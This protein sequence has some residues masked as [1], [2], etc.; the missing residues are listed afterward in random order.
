MTQAKTKAF[1]SEVTNKL[2]LFGTNPAF[3][4]WDNDK[5]YHLNLLLLLSSVGAFIFTFFN[6]WI[7]NALLVGCSLAI[8]GYNLLLFYLQYSQ[9][10]YTARTL[11][12]VGYPILF[13]ALIVCGQGTI[14]A[15]YA[16]F[17]MTLLC[18]LFFRSTWRLMAM[19]AYVF[20]FYLISQVLLLQEY[21]AISDWSAIVNN[22]ILFL[23][24]SFG[25]VFITN[26][27]I[28]EII[29][30]NKKNTQLLSDLADSNEELKRLNYMVSHDLRT[31]LRH[32][33]SF[34]KIAQ[35]ASQKGEPS[36]SQ[37]YM[38]L[39]ENSARELYTMTENLLSLAHLDQNQLHTESVIL[40]EVFDKIKRQFAKVEGST[41]ISIHLQV[42]D[43]QLNASPIL[44]HMVL[45]N[46]VENGIKYNE[47]PHKQIWL[48]AEEHENAILIFVKDNGI[49]IP[50]TDRNAIFTVF[51]RLNQDKYQGTG[52]GLAIAKKIMDIHGGS[53]VV[54]CGADGSV[55]TLRFPKEHLNEEGAP[56]AINK[57]LP[58]KEIYQLSR[59]SRAIF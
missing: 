31:P 30:S 34:S 32:I 58:L 1:F 4:S 38:Q 12:A 14:K 48:K 50:E 39:I 6:L 41:D 43:H 25:V 47:S 56:V 17:L 57:P 40:D 16:F 27:F 28:R 49:G 21:N 9:R 55:F 23:S 33:I 3:I 42:D 51:H 11:T 37:E 15:E 36:S 53:I 18:V 2:L 54:D 7:N 24:I 22:S 5:T 13:F 26:N 8:I 52:L 45:Q 20:V 59:R 10:Q 19:I 29:H 35:T 46:L 44:L